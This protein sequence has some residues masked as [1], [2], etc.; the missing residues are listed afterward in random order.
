LRIPSNAA[1]E[2]A[3]PIYDRA[4]ELVRGLYDRRLSGPPVL[5]PAAHFPGHE[6]FTGAVPALREE[7]LRIVGGLAAVP[8]FHELM[9]Q[10][11]SISNQDKRDWRLL[12]VK[13][14]GVTV[15]ANARR[16]PALTQLV[17]ADPDVLSAALSF[18]APGKVVPEHRGP[19]RGVLRYFLGLSVPADGQG[20]PGSVLTIDGIEHRIATGNALLWDDTYVHAVRN[21]TQSVRVALLLDIRRRS[22]PLDMEILSRI[23]IAAAAV[24]VRLRRI[25]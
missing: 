17:A 8:R 20:R 13:A 23:L 11:A 15:K 22:M 25:S 2:S 14:Y 1:K 24:A 9:P 21:E 12:V 16:C 19:F 10:Q 18:L 6:R 5:E 4:V 3:S 7:A